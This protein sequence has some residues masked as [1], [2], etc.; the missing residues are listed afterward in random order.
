MHIQQQCLPILSCPEGD[1]LI[2]N[3]QALPAEAA[4]LPLGDHLA[5]RLQ[6]ILEVPPVTLHRVR[7]NDLP[8]ALEP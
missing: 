8:G 3:H 1:P 5:Y 4:R 2:G 6:H 7:S